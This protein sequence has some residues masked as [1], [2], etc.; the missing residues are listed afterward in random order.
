MLVDFEK[1]FRQ[2]NARNDRD[3]GDLVALLGQK[4][5][6]RRLG[7]P[8]EADDNDVRVIEALGAPAVVV[9]QRIL[10][11]VDAFEIPFIDLSEQARS[12]ERF[13][14]KIGREV[15]YERAQNVEMENLVL[16]A[17][18]G[19]IVPHLLFDK[20]KS[21]EGLVRLGLVEDLFRARPWNQCRG[22]A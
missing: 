11:R 22:K 17:V 16:H 14:S 10:D 4:E 3:I 19:R 8:R 7:R 1:L 13:Q 21:D 5:R 12:F 6:G 15:V 2:G 18:V 9:S 20:G